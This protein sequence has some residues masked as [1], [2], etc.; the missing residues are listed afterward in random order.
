MECN[1]IH[2][3]AIDSTNTWAKQNVHLFDSKKITLVTAEMQHEGRGRFKRRWVSPSGLNMYASFCFFIL[4][5][6][7]DLS[8]IGHVI[9][10]SAVKVLENFKIS[11]KLK[12]PNDLILNGKKLGGI[13]CETQDMG[14]EFCIIAGIGINV[15]M[16]VEILEQIDQ[17]ATSLLQIKKELLELESF[18][19]AFQLQVQKD[20]ALFQREGFNPFYPE[21]QLSLCHF[22]GQEMIVQDGEIQW[23]GYFAGIHAN[24]S[25]LL[26]LQS[27]EIKQISS[28]E[29]SKQMLPDANAPIT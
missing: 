21:Y 18:I 4:K 17:P 23:Q 22:F 9:G 15:N 2:F 29:I 6:K 26:K 3:S 14:Q 13:L 19:T 10:V 16:P 25:L 1:R 20:I 24:G 11:L 8:T 28:G 27:N 5:E 12:W 7:K